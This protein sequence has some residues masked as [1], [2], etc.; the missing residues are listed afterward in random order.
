[1]GRVQIE[2]G[3]KFSITISKLLVCQAQTSSR[4]NAINISWHYSFCSVRFCS[5]FVVLICSNLSSLCVSSRLL[6]TRSKQT[7]NVGS[8]TSWL[9]WLSWL[10]GTLFWC[11]CFGSVL[12]LLMMPI[13]IWQISQFFIIRLGLCSLSLKLCKK[14]RSWPEDGRERY[15]KKAKRVYRD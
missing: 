6:A 4:K 12:F 3:C 7:L 5:C 2:F 1:M 10:A 15:E 13:I 14:T 8:L 9:C 11:C